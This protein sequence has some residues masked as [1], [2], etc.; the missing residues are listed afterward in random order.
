MDNPILLTLSQTN[1]FIVFN[2]SGLRGVRWAN[3]MKTAD[4]LHL[5]PVSKTI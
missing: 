3:A 5:K 2:L 4:W 1:F